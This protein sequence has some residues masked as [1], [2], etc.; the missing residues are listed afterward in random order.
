MYPTYK[1][2]EPLTGYTDKSV[3]GFLLLR[4]ILNTCH[5]KQEG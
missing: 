2:I 4:K 1:T 3:S 5:F